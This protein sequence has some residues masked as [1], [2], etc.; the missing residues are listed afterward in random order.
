MEI[1][2]CTRDSFKLLKNQM[3]H[4]FI[5]SVHMEV[6]KFQSSSRGMHP[7]TAARGRSSSDVKKLD[8]L[9]LS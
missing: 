2:T 8:P 7:P 1:H 9:F 6:T 3:T 4:S 5:Y